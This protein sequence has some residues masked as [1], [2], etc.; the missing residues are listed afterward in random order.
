MDFSSAD[1]EE[2]HEENYSSILKDLKS[3]WMTTEISH[4]VSK[5]ASDAFWRLGLEYFPKISAA[6]VNKKT[7]QFD[8]IRRRIYKD[9][10]PPI[11]LQIAFKHR[12]SG[13]IVVVN[14]TVTPIKNYSPAVYDKMYEIATIKV[15]YLA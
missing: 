2:E 10:V 14:N 8:S 6:N 15:N 7:H 9:M 4:C 13:E 11:H 1:D 3:Q 5:A 12:A